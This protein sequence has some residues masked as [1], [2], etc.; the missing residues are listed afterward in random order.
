MEGSDQGVTHNEFLVDVG[1]RPF[2]ETSYVDTDH[3]SQSSICIIN[4]NETTAIKLDDTGSEGQLSNTSLIIN[5]EQ[6]GFGT[7]NK[8]ISFEN[9]DREIG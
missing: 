7:N 6:Y 9:V 1:Q 5:K 4:H 2:N 3:I 8:Y